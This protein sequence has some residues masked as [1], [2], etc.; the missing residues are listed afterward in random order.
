[1]GD[2]AFSNEV[3]F[4][5][6]LYENHVTYSIMIGNR[7]SV[8]DP[9]NGEPVPEEK[10]AEFLLNSIQEFLDAITEDT[11]LYNMQVIDRRKKD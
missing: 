1:M 5:K 7:F 8:Y 4:N 2:R 9:V 11:V 10:I 3:T 6:Y